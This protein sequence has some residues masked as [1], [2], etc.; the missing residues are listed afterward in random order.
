MLKESSHEVDWS[1]DIALL[2]ATAKDVEEK[3]TD[4]LSGGKTTTRV[5]RQSLFRFK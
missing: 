2:I 4:V 1:L 5:A 3:A